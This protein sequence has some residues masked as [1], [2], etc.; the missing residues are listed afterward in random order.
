MTSLG[1]SICGIHTRVSAHETPR[2]DR[3]HLGYGHVQ[4]PKHINLEW[5]AAH[6]L[7]NLLTNQLV[8]HNGACSTALMCQCNKPKKDLNTTRIRCNNL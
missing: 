4:V 1:I 7:P 3:G 8:A 6:K 5:N 2:E